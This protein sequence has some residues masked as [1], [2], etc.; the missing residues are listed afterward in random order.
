MYRDDHCPLQ[1]ASFKSGP[2]LQVRGGCVGIDAYLAC[3]VTFTYPIC[4]IYAAKDW[5]KTELFYDVVC[6]IIDAMGEKLHMIE[7]P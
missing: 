3:S 7:N 2:L 1:W 4:F 5:H 6:E